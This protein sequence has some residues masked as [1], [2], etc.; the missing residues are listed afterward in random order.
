MSSIFSRPLPPPSRKDLLIETVERELERIYPNTLEK[1]LKMKITDV[2][3][4]RSR[5]LSKLVKGLTT[6]HLTGLI[7]QMKRAPVYGVNHG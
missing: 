5:K 7:S 1:D 6:K 3:I 4:F 2:V